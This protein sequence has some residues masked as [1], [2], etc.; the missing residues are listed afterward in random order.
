MLQVP[1]N[2]NIPLKKKKK[3]KTHTIL[4]G[5]SSSS[6]ILFFKA[7]IVILPLI[8]EGREKIFMQIPVIT[9][10]HN[11]PLYDS[12]IKWT[13]SEA[14]HYSGACCIKQFSGERFRN[15]SSLTKKFAFGEIF[16]IFNPKFVLLYFLPLCFKLSHLFSKLTT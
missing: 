15:D 3:K 16:S 2:A 10:K 5:E 7:Y 1:F 6:Q 9:I 8:L 11:T 13:V 4:L 14:S 12:K